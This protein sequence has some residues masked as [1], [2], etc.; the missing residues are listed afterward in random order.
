[1]KNA[2]PYYNELFNPY[3][4]DTLVLLHIADINLYLQKFDEAIENY[5]KA[6]NNMEDL[7][8]INQALLLAN[9][10]FCEC[11]FKGTQNETKLDEA[12][13]ILN[14]L[15]ENYDNL[16]NY[17]CNLRESMKQGTISSDIPVQGTANELLLKEQLKVIDNKV[18]GVANE[19]D[20]TVK[21][22]RSK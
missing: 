7:L 2:L 19:I 13:K 18:Q 20:Q 11:K 3:C 10:T 15:N 21:K 1:M 22:T 16:R 12:I 6:Y 4:A 17:I 9:Y 8:P 5:E 14:N